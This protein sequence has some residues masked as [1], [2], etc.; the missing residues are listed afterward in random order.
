MADTDLSRRVMLGS[1]AIGSIAAAVSVPA[2]V[3]VAAPVEIATLLEIERKITFFTDA[4]YA[5]INREYGLN[6]RLNEI[7]CE[8]RMP[9]SRPNETVTHYV[10]RVVQSEARHAARR[11]RLSK[12]CGLADC[13]ERQEAY[14]EKIKALTERLYATKATTIE[15]LRIK[16]R[17]APVNGHAMSSILQDLLEEGVHA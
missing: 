7:T 14:A 13:L 9:N 6:R 2:I 17:I 11:D 15:G 1:L 10:Y 4:R 12:E 5:E 8:H 3:A 16:A